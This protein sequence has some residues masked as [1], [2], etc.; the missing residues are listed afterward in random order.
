[1]GEEPG[2]DTWS[3]SS[4]RQ[5]DTEV[6]RTQF[7]SRAR[8]LFRRYLEAEAMGQL[9]DHQ[10]AFIDRNAQQSPAGRYWLLVL[11]ERRER[12]VASGSGDPAAT[13]LDPF[14]AEDLGRVEAENDAAREHAGDP[15]EHP[16]P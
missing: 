2:I 10:Q 6:T 15:G 8:A 12:E 14:T 4:G 13:G 1:M 3:G 7:R 11:L 9:P 5:S 16:A